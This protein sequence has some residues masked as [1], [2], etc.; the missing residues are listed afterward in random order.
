LAGSNAEDAALV[1]AW[2]AA[3]TTGC[4]VAAAG[5]AVQADRK[6]NAMIRINGIRK[7]LF[8]FFPY[9]LSL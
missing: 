8:I 1:G 9:I 4:W 7:V 2:V 5:A 3:A 6:A